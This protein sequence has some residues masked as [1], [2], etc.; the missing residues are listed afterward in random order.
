MKVQS[1][2]YPDFISKTVDLPLISS[3]KTK[4]CPNYWYL[5]LLICEKNVANYVLLRCKTFSLKIWLCKI[6][7]KYHVCVIPNWKL[8]SANAHF[9]KF[10]FLEHGGNICLPPFAQFAKQ[11]FELLD[12]KEN[13]N[14]WRN[15][16]CGQ[17][18][19]SILLQIQI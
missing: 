17:S 8:Y 9:L 12:S 13:F 14:L 19:E 7:D 10:Y 3:F 4:K 2:F 16:S 1:R 6:L 15:L 5:T 11:T 18:F